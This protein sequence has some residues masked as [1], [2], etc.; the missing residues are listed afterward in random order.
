MPFWRRRPDDPAIPETPSEIDPEAV[1]ADWEPDPA[2][3]DDLVTLARRTK[4]V[5]ASTSFSE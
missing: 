5:S 3:F 2:D 1:L 4:G